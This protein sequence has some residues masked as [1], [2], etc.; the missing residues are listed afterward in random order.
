MFV[1]KEQQQILYA[2]ISS[3]EKNGMDRRNNPP[4][5]TSC[6]DLTEECTITKG[7]NINIIVY[8][9]NQF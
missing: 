7:C 9:S 5:A 8:V 1:N 3:Q 6:F 4:K 2:L